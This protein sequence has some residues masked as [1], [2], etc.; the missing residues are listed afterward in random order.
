MQ[1]STYLDSAIP[2]GKFYL[3]LS[4]LSYVNTLYIGIWEQEASREI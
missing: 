3:N 1:D 2:K 4:E